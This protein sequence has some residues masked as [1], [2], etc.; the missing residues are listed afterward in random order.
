MHCLPHRRREI[1][2][3]ILTLET[4][5]PHD[6]C[7]E[8]VASLCHIR[9]GKLAPFVHSH[10]SAS[11]NAAA[12]ARARRWA[13]VMVGV[14]VKKSWLRV[15]L[16]GPT[17]YIKELGMPQRNRA[18][19]CCCHRC[20]AGAPCNTLASGISEPNVTVFL[21]RIVPW[22]PAPTRDHICTSAKEMP[23]TVAV[24][25]AHVTRRGYGGHG[26]KGR[27]PSVTGCGFPMRWRQCS[28]PSRAALVETIV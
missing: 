12:T 20:V 24:S 19:P 9:K 27:L 26:S 6:K 1:K 21:C 13:K 28:M 23:Q 4:Q 5:A 14:S 16:N 3:A 15:T 7:G 2:A 18:T 25:F 10:F 11:S 22:S 8:Y 17:V